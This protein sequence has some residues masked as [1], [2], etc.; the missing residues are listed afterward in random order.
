MT[1]QLTETHT[2]THSL[3]NICTVSETSA[4]TL[5]IIIIKLTA[6]WALRNAFLALNFEKLYICTKVCISMYEFVRVFVS[7]CVLYFIADSKRAAGPSGQ[8]GL[9][10]LRLPVRPLAND[11]D[12]IDDDHHHH[13]GCHGP[14]RGKKR[15]Q[16]RTQHF[17]LLTHLTRRC[18]NK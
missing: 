6:L 14:K 18:K 17:P 15:R 12:A 1:L 16:R 9:L 2:L 8:T 7:V 11:D 13:V 4:K 10:L 3:H 5:L